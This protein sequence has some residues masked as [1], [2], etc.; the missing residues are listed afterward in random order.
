[1]T[2]RTQLHPKSKQLFVYH[3]KSGP[4][5]VSRTHHDVSS[6]DKK[7]QTVYHPRSLSTCYVSV[8]KHSKNVMIS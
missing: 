8:Q 4:V 3:T 1:M 5:S 6:V 2:T 7:T